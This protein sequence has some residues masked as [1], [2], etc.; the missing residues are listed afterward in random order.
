MRLSLAA[1]DRVPPA[2]RPAYDPAALKT[3]MVHLGVG[4]FH[5]AH[6]AVFTDD[7]IAGHG[8]GWGVIG[9]AMRKP[10]A[11]LALRAQD[12]L[13]TVE[14]LGA[15]LAYR[16]IGAVRGALTLPL[17]PARVAAAIADPAV[18]IVTLT[19]TEKG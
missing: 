16:V 5:R 7:A 15:E 18:R 14:Y 4:A 1:L 19:V 2:M 10:D 6:Q 8:G 3:G 9:V 17:E 13:Y 11:A 12:G